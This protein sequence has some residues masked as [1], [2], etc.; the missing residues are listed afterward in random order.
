MWS[1]R[2]EG[3]VDFYLIGGIGGYY[4]K[5]Q[6]TEPGLFVG[7]YCDPWWW[8]CYDYIVEGDVI[9]DSVSTTKFGAN[10]GVGVSFELANK[11]LIY[12]ETRYHYINT[13]ESTVYLPIKIGYRW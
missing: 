5:G 1:T 7:T 12:I 2:N 4:L 8:W 6:L 10:A 9:V 11:S 13:K 3:K